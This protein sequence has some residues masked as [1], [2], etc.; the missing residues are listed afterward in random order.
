[1]RIIPGANPDLQSFLIGGH[2]ADRTRELNFDL[3]EY[4]V[5]M[6]VNRIQI[7]DKSL[8]LVG[9]LYDDGKVEDFVR[10]KEKDM[11]SIDLSYNPNREIIHPA[12]MLAEDGRIYHDL[13]LGGRIG[14]ES[15][16]LRDFLKLVQRKDTINVGFR[17]FLSNFRPYRATYSGKA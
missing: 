7:L 6:K 16:R 13:D 17:S 9:M 14:R 5:P 2:T 8:D 3:R 1:M 12:T 11:V 15:K 4:R 10:F